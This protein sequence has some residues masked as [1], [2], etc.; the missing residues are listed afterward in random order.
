MREPVAPLSH[1]DDKFLG[2]S[3]EGEGQMHSQNLILC[4]V[5]GQRL[6]RWA[7]AQQTLSHMTGG[8]LDS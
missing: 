4:H 6:E 8:Q 7:W 5:T 3:T 1:I 2:M